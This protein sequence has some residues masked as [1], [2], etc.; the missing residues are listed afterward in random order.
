MKR[1]SKQGQCIVPRVQFQSNLELLFVCENL[2]HLYTELV[3]RVVS[4]KLALRDLNPLAWTELDLLMF[5]VST[6]EDIM[7]EA[8]GL[9]LDTTKGNGALYAHELNARIVR[10]INWH[11]VIFFHG[12]TS[13][14]EGDLRNGLARLMMRILMS[15]A[16]SH[17]H[18]LMDENFKSFVAWDGDAWLL[19]PRHL[20]SEY[21]FTITIV[22]ERNS[23]HEDVVVCILRLLGVALFVDREQDVEEKYVEK[24]V[25]KEAQENDVTND[26]AEIKI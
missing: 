10:C 15:S 11:N 26:V 1:Y 2:L 23:L 24:D 17:Y 7:D 5:G 14:C 3:Q 13:W 25:K 21:M 22:C 9:V 16:S 18:L 8:L 12:K 4:Q 20:V 19:C 6:F